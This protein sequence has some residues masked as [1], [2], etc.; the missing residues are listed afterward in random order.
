MI[1]RKEVNW[2]SHEGYRSSLPTQPWVNVKESEG[3]FWVQVA[4]PG[5][6]KSD[7]EIEVKEQTLL[8]SVEKESAEEVFVRQ[9]FDF[10]RF[11]R[12]FYLPKGTDRNQIQATYEAG[13]LTI[14]IPKREEVIQK[15]AVL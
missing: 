6:S 12:A 13:I 2:K 10:T 1:V 7:F 4:A 11:K 5:L 3:S 9:E 14:E 15:V 8:I